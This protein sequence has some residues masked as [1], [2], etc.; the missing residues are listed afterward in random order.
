MISPPRVVTRL[1]RRLRAIFALRLNDEKRSRW[2]GSFRYRSLS[3]PK[4][5]FLPYTRSLRGR[6]TAKLFMVKIQQIISGNRP[7]KGQFSA[8]RKIIDAGL[9]PGGGRRF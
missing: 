3:T 4:N 2:S 7:S 1:G 9:I 5:I 6:F 8:Y